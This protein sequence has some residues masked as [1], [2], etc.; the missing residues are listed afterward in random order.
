MDDYSEVCA[1]PLAPGACNNHGPVLVYYSYQ[2]YANSLLE[3]F[4]IASHD[5]Y[6][7]GEPALAIGLLLFVLSSAAFAILI[8]KNKSDD[9][10]DPENEK[11]RSK[12]DNVPDVI[13]I[14]PG[15]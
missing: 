15:E 1:T 13:H 7:I 3:D 12:S 14:V 6:R 8:R 11:G 4:T 2:P 5:G 9:D 10:G